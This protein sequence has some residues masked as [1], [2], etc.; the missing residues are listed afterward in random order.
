[1]G[2][3]GETLISGQ[4]TSKQSGIEARVSDVL[5]RVDNSCRLC[6]S[7]TLR[8]F[9]AEISGH[10]F[11]LKNIDKPTVWVF[12]K[13]VGCLHCGLAEFLIPE[14]ELRLLADGG[15]DGASE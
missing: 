5:S 15:S 6:G 11:A 8:E 14:T 10:C 9:T 2:T 13:L 4:G 7:T 1:M 3:S 12:P